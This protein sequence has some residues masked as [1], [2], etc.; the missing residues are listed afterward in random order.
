MHDVYLCFKMEVAFCTGRLYECSCCYVKRASE[1][2]NKE[3]RR[4]LQKVLSERITEVKDLEEKEPD[5]LAEA[6]DQLLKNHDYD[7]S[8][9]R[10]SWS[11]R[12]SSGRGCHQEWPFPESVKA[13]RGERMTW[14]A[15]RDVIKDGSE[16]IMQCEEHVSDFQTTMSTF[17]PL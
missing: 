13:R 4:A 1:I 15:W 17:R 2:T 6:I 3:F 14:R 12:Y 8:W 7:I 16:L 10:L 11:T 5:V 9:R